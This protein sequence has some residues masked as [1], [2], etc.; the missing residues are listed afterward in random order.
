MRMMQ[1]IL[2]ALLHL[3]A[4]MSAESIGAVLTACTTTITA[5]PADTVRLCKS[6]YVYTHRKDKIDLRLKIDRAM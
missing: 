2:V 3:A 4:A 1:F 6:S 5:G